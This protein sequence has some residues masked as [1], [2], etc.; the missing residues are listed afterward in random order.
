[1]VIKW[2]VTLPELT[3]N[4]ERTAYLYLPESYNY[5]PYKRYPVLYMFD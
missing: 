4:E 3:G 1:M 2:K 5:E